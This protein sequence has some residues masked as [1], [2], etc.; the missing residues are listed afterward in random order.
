MSMSCLELHQIAFFPLNF[1]HGYISLMFKLS[2]ISPIRLIIARSLRFS[3][4]HCT[5][6]VQSSWATSSDNSNVLLT[7]WR[8]VLII[9]HLVV[10]RCL[11]GKQFFSIQSWLWTKTIRMIG[12]VVFKISSKQ[13]AGLLIMHACTHPFTHTYYISQLGQTST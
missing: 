4:S 9:E 3:W 2:N 7:H 5:L 6:V 1:P 10:C 12:P 13:D 11:P 8:S